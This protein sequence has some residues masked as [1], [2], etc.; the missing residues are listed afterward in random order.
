MWSS[1]EGLF[2]GEPGTAVPAGGEAVHATSE[3]V[4]ATS[5]AVHANRTAHADGPAHADRTAHADG[6]AHADRTA[7]ADGP[8]HADG[9]VHADGPAQA[10]RTAP[11]RA[12]LDHVPA[13][14]RHRASL[15]LVLA[16]CTLLVLIV[17]SAAVGIG[18]VVIS[19]AAAW[20]VVI[21]HL[22]GRS[23]GTVDDEIIWQI[24]LP[25]V[26]LAAVVGAALT[27]TVPAVVSAAPSCRCSSATR[28]PTRTCSGSRPG[29]ASAPPR[30]CCSAPLPRLACGPSRRAA[31]SAPWSR[32]R[33]CSRWPGRAARSRRPSSSCAAW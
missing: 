5:E 9:T 3:A 10:D 25:R 20:H 17:I 1:A 19:P 27:T 8:A 16:G 22:A 18:S 2:V 15:P 30:S 28:W 26:L 13:R 24:R 33:P 32:W 14:R 21:S 7:H 29:P 11:V 12:E 31:S 4:H 23:A 6:P